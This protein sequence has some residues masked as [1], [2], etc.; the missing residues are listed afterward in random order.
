M[1][2]Y[3]SLYLLRHVVAII[4]IYC[5]LL[6]IMLPFWARLMVAPPARGRK[7][8]TLLVFRNSGGG[9]WFYVQ[10][11]YVKSKNTYAF[12]PTFSDIYFIGWFNFSDIFSIFS[13]LTAFISGTF[14]FFYFFIFPFNSSWSNVYTWVDFIFLKAHSQY[15]RSR[16]L[17]VLE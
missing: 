9:C 2:Q 10:K 6:K 16:I 7:K 8:V 4:C 14:H 12:E 3:E 1:I 11:L 13:G 5:L 17:I 15:T